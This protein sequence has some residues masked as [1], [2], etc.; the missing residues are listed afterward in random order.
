MYALGGRYKNAQKTY[1]ILCRAAWT[2]KLLEIEDI[3]TTQSPLL[4]TINNQVK[5]ETK[6]KN[7]HIWHA[8][9]QIDRKNSMSWRHRLTFWTYKFLVSTYKKYKLNVTMIAT[10]G[11]NILSG[12]L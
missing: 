12:L 9:F 1:I 8:G 7:E 3:T 2:G 4:P 5:V 6:T 10:K 11:W